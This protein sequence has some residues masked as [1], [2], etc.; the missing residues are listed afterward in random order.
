M[1]HLQ[2][3]GKIPSVSNRKPVKESVLR[4]IAF[5]HIHGV[6]DLF[7]YRRQ[8]FLI[9]MLFFCQTKKDNTVIDKSR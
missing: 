5:D 1:I 9:V 6:D 3:T 4:G 8:G 2:P 7:P